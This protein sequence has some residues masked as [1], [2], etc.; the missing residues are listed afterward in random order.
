MKDYVKDVF[1][2]LIATTSLGEKIKQHVRGRPSFSIRE[3]LN[4]LKHRE[5]FSS[6]ILSRYIEMLQ[7]HTGLIQFAI[8]RALDNDTDNVF[9][10]RVGDHLNPTKRNEIVDKVDDEAKEIVK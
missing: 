1:E 7:G 8:S 6:K 2:A 10:R 9:G 4:M 5:H 3:A